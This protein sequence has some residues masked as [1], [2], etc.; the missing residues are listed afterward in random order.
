M[1]VGFHDTYSFS[2]I[3]FHMYKAH[4]VRIPHPP[5]YHM[6]EN[7]SCIELFPCPCQ[8][9]VEIA[10]FLKHAKRHLKLKLATFPVD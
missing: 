1:Q 5:L 7:E 9:P 6:K 3:L 2:G 8:R 4:A 10:I